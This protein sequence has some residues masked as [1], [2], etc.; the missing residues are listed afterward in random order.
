MNNTN[1]VYEWALKYI[2]YYSLIPVGVDKKPLI[3]WKKYQTEKPSL[4]QL[5]EWFDKPSPP[6]IGIVT[7][8]ISGITVVD[9]E[10][11]GKWDDFPSTMTAKTGGGGVHLFYRYAP[12]VNNKARIRPLTDIRGDGGYVVAAPSIHASGQKYE[13]I[14]KELTQPFPYGMF[15]L[16]P[17]TKTDWTELLAGVNQGGRNQTASQVIGKFIST[18]HPEDWMTVAWQMTVVWNNGNQPPLQERE[19]RATFNSIIGRE[20]RN[21]K[22]RIEEKKAEAPSVI[23]DDC[24]IK[25]MSQIAGDITDDMTVSYPTGYKDIDDNFM[26]GLKEGDLFFITGYSGHGKTSICQTM[27]Y[28][29][30]RKGHPTMWFSFEVPIGEVWRKFKDMKVGDNFQAYAPE[31]I[32]TPNLEW[33]KKKIIEA[34]D[35][36]KTKIV[37]IDHL[38]YL[39]MEPKNYDSNVANNLSTI[40]GMICRQLK[41]L[42]IQ[43]NVAIVLLGHLRKPMTGRTE[44]PTIHDIKD[45]AGV[46]QESDA[47]IIIH[48]KRKAVKDSGT[49]DIFERDTTVKIEKN[50]RTGKNKSFTVNMIDGRLIDGD[51]QIDLAMNF[52]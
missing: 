29:L 13:W 41:T 24:D 37:F 35:R 6:N 48:R 28:N 39:A 34:R 3:E 43:E 30:D 33:V 2:K 31:K 11:D 21:G 50:R 45:S 49:D 51:E 26:G 32:I 22:K 20:V 1:T 15:N 16:N 5:K 4:E 36:F 44:E 8:K 10:K 17:E 42:A 38:G 7:G 19:L 23:E 18:L 14:K 46:S 47:V 12:G 27:T 25:L 52:K 40:M 9:V